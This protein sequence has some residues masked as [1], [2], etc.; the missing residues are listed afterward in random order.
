MKT[1]EAEANGWRCP[2]CGG[3]LS[4]DPGEKGYVRH[5]EHLSGCDDG[6]VYGLGERDE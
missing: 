4:G 6:D 1:S 3:R 2:R 5:L